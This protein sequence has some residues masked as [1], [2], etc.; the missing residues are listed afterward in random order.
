MSFLFDKKTK[1][2]IKWIW[3]FFAI[4][5]AVSMVFAYSG[6]IGQ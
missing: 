2:T 4:I 5:I 3:A 1:K 6:G